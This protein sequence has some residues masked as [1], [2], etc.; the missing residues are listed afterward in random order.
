MLGD[1]KPFRIIGNTYFVG[2][3]PASSHMIDTGDGLILIDT[4]YAHTA[5][6]VVESVTELGFN[7]C[8]VKYIIHSHGHYDH[9]GGTEKIVALSGAKT[10]LAKEDCKYVVGFEPDYDLK[11]G[12]IIKLGKTEILCLRTPGHTE[13]TVSLFWNEEEDGKVYRLGTFGGAGTAQVRKDY[14]N[15]C[16]CSYLNR[17]LFFESIERL[18]REHVDVFIGNHAGQNNT[19]ENSEI[20]RRTGIN[21]FIDDTKW[22]AFLEKVEASLES[23]FIKDSREYFVNYAHRGASEYAPEN[24]FSA[25][26]MGAMMGANGIETDV[27]MTKDGVLVLFHDDTI[28]RLTGEKGSV[29]DYTLEELKKFTFEKNGFTGKIA[30]FE[31][32]LKQFGMRTI[33]LAIEIKQAGIEK[34]VVDMIC[35]YDCLKKVIVTSFM[36]D[37]IKKVK[38]YAPNIRVGCLVKTVDDAILAQLRESKVDELCPLA[39]EVTD[40]NVH[41]WHRMGFNVRAWGVKNEELMRRVYDS[42]ADGMTVNFPDKLTRYIEEKNSE[43]CEK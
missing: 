1:I 27:Q 23:K 32:F 20:M 36:F 33:E 24:T 28:E 3:Q 14:L 39:E 16:N 30:V 8:D 12:D 35:K 6:V 41:K 2:T 42:M 22:L 18:K 26:H 21:P 31:E 29:S 37:S 9:T 10:F 17:G 34:K 4:G 43:S 19:R 11:D 7:I 13:G 38:E 40:S 25:F 5:D 15:R